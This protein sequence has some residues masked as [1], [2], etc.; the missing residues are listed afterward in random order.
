MKKLSSKFKMVSGIAVGSLLVGSVGT[1]AATGGSAMIEVFYN[2]AHI[3]IN[4][5]SKMP[6]EGKPFIYNG[7]TYV[8]LRYVAENLGQAVGWDAATQTVLIG[9]TGTGSGNEIDFVSMVKSMNFQGMGDSY[10]AGFS[11]YL[12]KELIEG[13]GNATVRGK[14]KDNAGRDF[15]NYT[16]LYV[17][18]GSAINEYPLNGQY[19][20]FRATVGLPEEV[21]NTKSGL[22][23]Q[24]MADDKIL[25]TV[26]LKAGMFSEDVEVDVT[27]A[28]KLTLKAIHVGEAEEISVG[29][30][31]PK[32]VK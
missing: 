21:K 13:A 7:T 2:V 29:F 9:D 15:D 14:G 11:T 32:L 31:N 27:N 28:N 16:Y 24:I 3:K 12:N 4:N 10:Y 6:S 18:R 26:D 8:P 1:F 25:K 17:Y 23:V 30:F 22:T 19:K 20:K 5:E